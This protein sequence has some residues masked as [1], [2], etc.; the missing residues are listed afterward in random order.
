MKIAIPLFHTRV[1]PRFDFAS[2]LMV[3]TVENNKV[4]SKEEISLKN[5]N[6]T[7]RTALLKDLGVTTLI[8]GGIQGFLARS[9]GNNNVQVIVPVAGEVR[10]VLE[11]F[12]GGK[13]YTTCF[14]LRSACRRGK[15]CSN[16]QR[17]C[18]QGNEKK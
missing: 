18:D 8:C 12:L 4:V 17:L 14:R 9:L 6:P 11:C 3:A 2:T 5:Y 10:N 16:R 7:Q 13:L 1:S 15:C